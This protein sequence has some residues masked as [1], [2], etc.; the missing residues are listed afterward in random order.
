MFGVGNEK[1][2]LRLL[3]YG[4]NTFDIDGY[5]DGKDEFIKQI[6]KD[7]MIWKMREDLL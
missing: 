7:A 6:E 2:F 1:K 5:C 4:R 3:K